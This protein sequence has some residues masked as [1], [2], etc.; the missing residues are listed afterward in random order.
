MAWRKLIRK[1]CVSIVLDRAI[2]KYI[3]NVINSYNMTVTSLINTLLNCES[4]AFAENYRY[5]MY[6]YN[7]PS[8]LWRSD[9]KTF[10]SNISYTDDINDWQ[11]INISPLQELCKM[12][13]GILYMCTNKDKIII[14]IIYIHANLL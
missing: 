1:I 14:I 10:I 5:I 12:R 7:I 9:L 4:S 8:P 3:F 6:T 13:N 2:A 11:R